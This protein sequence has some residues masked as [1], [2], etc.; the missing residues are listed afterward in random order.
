MM[1]DAYLMAFTMMMVRRG[2][3]R[4]DS[5]KGYGCSGKREDEGFHVATPMKS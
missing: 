3:R 1:M 5:R 2:D 4:D